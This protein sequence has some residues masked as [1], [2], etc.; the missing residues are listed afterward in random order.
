MIAKFILNIKQEQESRLPLHGKGGGEAPC[1]LLHSVVPGRLNLV[2][3]LLGGRLGIVAES[4]EAGNEPANFDTGNRQRV[5]PFIV[6]REP[7]AKLLSPENRAWRIT[8]AGR[9]FVAVT[10][11]HGA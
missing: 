9:D 7:A 2:E 5:F 11:R 6:R 3:I 8:P 4:G 1:L 10:N